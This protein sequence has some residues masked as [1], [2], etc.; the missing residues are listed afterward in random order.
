MLTEWRWRQGL[1]CGALLLL[2]AAGCMLTSPLEDYP[3]EQGEGG[4][5]SGPGGGSAGSAV[6][7]GAAGAGKGGEAGAAPAEGMCQTNADCKSGSADELYRCRPSDHTCQVLKTGECPIAEGNATHPDAIFFGS[8]ANLNAAAPEDNAIVQAQLLALDDFSGEVFGGLPN[9]RRPLVLVVCNNSEEAAPEGLRHLVED[10][11]VPGVL[12]TLRP[13]DLRRGFD[14]YGS[15]DV[16]FLSPVS[17]TKSIV[18]EDDRGLIWNLLGQPADFSSAYQS[19]LLHAEAYVRKPPV[20]AVGDIRVALVTTDNAFDSELEDLIAPLL[21]FNGKFISGNA[22][23]YKGFEVTSESDLTEVGYDIAV[24]SPHIVVSMSGGVMT[25]QGGLIETIEAEWEL[26]AKTN[27][28]PPL[29]LLSPYDSGDLAYVELYIASSFGGSDETS[30]ANRFVGLSIASAEDTSL[31]NAYAVRLRNKFKDAYSDTANYYDAFYFLTY[32]S[33]AA[34][35][36]E[37]LTGA[38]IARG[39]QRLLAGPSFDPV[40]SV[41]SDVFDVLKEPEATIKLEST[42]GPPGFDP[43]NGSRP[44]DASLLCFTRAGESVM[45]HRDVRRFDRAMDEFVGEGA[46]CSSN[47]VP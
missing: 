45:L 28:P 17:V 40:P 12:A 16:F 11:E 14:E 29:F 13:G 18:N 47:M 36:D 43:I 27:Q 32:A 6:A 39:M 7:V 3:T 31:Q 42:L 23:N 22:E 25:I 34:G 30:A 44:I 15:R 5:D 26:A 37:P 20:S 21:E 19:L 2:V 33:F 35:T 41:I 10:L 8:F 24:F 9:P 46:F 38:G 4:N 1:L